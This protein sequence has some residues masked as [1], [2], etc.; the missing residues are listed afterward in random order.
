MIDWTLMAALLAIALGVGVCLWLARGRL[1]SD[2]EWRW[3]A[4]RRVSEKPLEISA[5]ERFLSDEERQVYAPHLRAI[6]KA[7]DG[8]RLM[9]MG[10]ADAG[11]RGIGL[12]GVG[13]CG[14]WFSRETG[15]NCGVAWSAARIKTIVVVD[16]DE[17]SFG[18]EG[19]DRPALR[20][21]IMGDKAE[22]CLSELGG[23]IGGSGE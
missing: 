3:G 13:I 5:A 2:I 23:A 15:A 17:A 12:I 8:Q 1:G 11:A 7:A 20:C 18:V 16:E 4:W 14:V 9:W 22:K 21:V 6:E 19:R 10:V